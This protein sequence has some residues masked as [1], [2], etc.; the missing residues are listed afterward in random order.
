M[1]VLKE[2]RIVKQQIKLNVKH[3][4]VM[5]FL[6]LLSY[7]HYQRGAVNQDIPRTAFRFVNQHAI[8][9][10]ET[11]TRTTQPFSSHDNINNA[12]VKN[13]LL[14]RFHALASVYPSMA[15]KIKYAHPD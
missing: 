15:P 9:T 12:G 14:H 8:P 1:L 5:R 13:T 7:L 4:L 3:L 11:I 6:H 2:L 10:P